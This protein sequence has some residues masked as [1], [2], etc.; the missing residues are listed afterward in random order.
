MTNTWVQ[1][2]SSSDLKNWVA[3]ANVLTTNSSVPYVDYPPPNS[4]TRFYRVVSPGP[5]AS[6]A[7]AA[8]QALKPE[9]YRYN[10]EN[11]KLDHG[12][13]LWACT[14]IMSNGIK[15]VINVTVN[16]NP[17]TS[18]EPNDFLTPDE[19]FALLISVEAS[20]TKLAHVSYHP[21]WGFPAAL[22]IVDSGSGV[23]QYRMFEFVP[24]P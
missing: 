23:I 12:G 13:G 8:W 19:L 20:G 7:R 14:V 9:H 15:S 24:D 16:G 4:T 5:S 21:E 2:E 6:D 22:N 3:V 10:F 17:A 1:V 18:F 11:V